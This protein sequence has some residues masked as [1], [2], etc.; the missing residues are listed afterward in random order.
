MRGEVRVF[1]ALL[2]KD[3]RVTARSPWELL[4]ILVF[5]SLTAIPASLMPVETLGVASR[6][7]LLFTTIYSSTQ[8][9]VREGRAGTIEVYH[10]YPIAP[11][12]HF[13]AK[14]LYTIILLQATLTLYATTLLLL[15]TPPGH[16]LNLAL[17]C[18]PP[19]I[20]LSAASSLASLLSTYLKSETTLLISITAIMA[21]PALISTSNPLIQAILGLAYV[22]IALIVVELM[23]EG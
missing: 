1:T 16:V 18:L 4:A 8:T 6:I 3:L 19:I 11:P 20:H 14:L 21:L 13:L 17:T 9:Y 7:V 2:L 15:G 5:S 12:I 10:L 23:E 22:I